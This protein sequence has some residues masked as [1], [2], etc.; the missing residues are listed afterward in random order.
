VLQ[1][2][3]QACSGEREYSEDTARMIAVEVQGLLETAHCRVWKTLTEKRSVLEALAKMLI[4]R[5]SWIA[6]FSLRY[7]PRRGHRQPTQ[8]QLRYLPTMREVASERNTTIFFP[9]PLYLFVSPLRAFS[10][11]EPPKN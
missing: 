8:A 7:W 9:F 11:V 10:A 2:S 4:E 6:R 5:R 1:L 3:W